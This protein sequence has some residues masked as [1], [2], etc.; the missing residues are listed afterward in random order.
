MSASGSS[1]VT[2]LG[3]CSTKARFLLCA[4]PPERA[5][6]GDASSEANASALSPSAP[7]RVGGRTSAGGLERSRFG[8]S[9]ARRSGSD[10][11]LDLSAR[12]EAREDSIAGA[13]TANARRG[14]A[15]SAGLAAHGRRAREDCA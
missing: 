3:A 10:A 15:R 11:A 8:P 7:D 14:R 2:G 12:G 6:P 4:A 13:G 9:D 5:A 1:R